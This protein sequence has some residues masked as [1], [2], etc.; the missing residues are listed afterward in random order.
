MHPIS[1][2]EWSWIVDCPPHS[3]ED[4][5]RAIRQFE[6][7]FHA[8]RVPGDGKFWYLRASELGLGVDLVRRSLLWRYHLQ[9]SRGH[10][11]DPDHDA[12]F[13]SD[14]HAADR[15]IMEF[16]DVVKAR[17]VEG[18]AGYHLDDLEPYGLLCRT[19]ATEKIVN[20]WLPHIGWVTGA[21]IGTVQDQVLRSTAAQLGR[22]VE[23]SGTMSWLRLSEDPS[24]MDIDELVRANQIKEA[25]Y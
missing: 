7:V 12:Q 25:L 9:F 24:M 18:M 2:K 3:I 23:E 19:D 4:S 21:R 11:C 22:S 14:W 20:G 13:V 10:E 16:S 17:R 15:S 1:L 8:P 5:Q 6:P